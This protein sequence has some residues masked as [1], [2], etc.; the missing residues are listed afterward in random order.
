MHLIL[1]FSLFSLLTYVLISQIRD[2]KYVPKDLNAW[3]A[4]R[5]W[6]VRLNDT[7][8]D[9]HDNIDVP[10]NISKIL[11]KGLYELNKVLEDLPQVHVKM[12]KRLNV[13]LIEIITD[14]LYLK[15]KISMMPWR[16]AFINEIINNAVYILAAFLFGLFIGYQTGCKI[17]VRLERNRRINAPQVE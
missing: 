16:T 13:Q 2:A 3:K 6:V 17:A 10:S 1:Q 14:S 7:L 8:D 15:M 5:G 9:M 4:Q 12:Q 11:K